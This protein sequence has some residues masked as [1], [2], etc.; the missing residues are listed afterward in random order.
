MSTP[1]VHHHDR[2]CDTCNT[3]IPR[4]RARNDCRLCHN[5]GV[6][7][8]TEPRL[9]GHTSNGL[10][11]YSGTATYRYACQCRTGWNRKAA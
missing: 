5:T 3:S 2:H 10:P 1:H 4:Y 6:E 7:T 11:V 9:I 8:R